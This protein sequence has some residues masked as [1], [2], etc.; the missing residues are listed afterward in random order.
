MKH[1][2][3]PISNGVT[4]ALSGGP[5]FFRQ[6]A[7][8]QLYAGSPFTPRLRGGYASLRLSLPGMTGP[9]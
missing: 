9:V 8:R 6:V 1:K 5:V 2:H 3:K 7:S 4:P